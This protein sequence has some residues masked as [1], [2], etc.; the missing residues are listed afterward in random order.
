MFSGSNITPWHKL[1]TV[2]TGL[3]SAKEALQAAHLDW[4]VEEAPVYVNRVGAMMD[5]QEYDR[6][7]DHKAL[8]RSDNHKALSVMRSSY[9]PIQNVEAFDFF[10]AIVGEG[11]AIYDT[12]GA[13]KDGRKVWI[14]AKL[15]GHLFIDGDEDAL[16]RNVLL[17]NSHDGSTAL[18]MQQ[19]GT[20]VVCQN[21]L[22][23][24]LSSAKNCISIF[25]C[26]DYKSRISESQRALRLA[27][28]YF[29]DLAG[30]MR[31]MAKSKFGS[32]D[33]RSFTTE[34]FPIA[35][36]EKAPSKEKARA[37]VFS[38]FRE[39]TG[40]RGETRYDALNA[41]TEFVDH[42]REYKRDGKPNAEARFA[43]VMFAGRTGANLK[44][45]AFALLSK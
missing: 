43:N 13:L 41:V 42:R 6:I 3:L 30:L 39:G 4:E 22:S 21:T 24:A 17:V 20:R 38:L 45:Q 28:A 26:G 5:G 14:M 40:C 34:L 7:P 10:D 15:P 1:G 2:V 12:A 37:E 8:V 25:H 9:Q 18:R 29:D 19:V 33:M 32:S 27:N 35:S 44:E 36:G 31:E 11:Q 23:I 16:E